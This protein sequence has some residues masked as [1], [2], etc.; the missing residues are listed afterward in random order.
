MIRRL[1]TLVLVLM[2]LGVAAG[3]GMVHHH[4]DGATDHSHCAACHWKV[5]ATADVPVS[6]ATIEYL[7]VATRITPPVVVCLPAQFVP[8]SASRA[9]PETSA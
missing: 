8:T 9:P 7:S 6:T 2:Y 4:E 3:L 1:T 5:S